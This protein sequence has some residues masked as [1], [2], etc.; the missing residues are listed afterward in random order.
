MNPP[1]SNAIARPA[2]QIGPD[3]FGPS[4]T[5][6]LWWLGGAGFLVNSHGTLLAID[7]AISLEP[8]TSDRSEVGFRLLVDLP[9]R[10]S[11]VPHLD[12][13][14]YTHTDVDH[15]APVTARELIRTAAAWVGPQPVIARLRELGV[16]GARPR[17]VKAG[18]RPRFGAVELETT[19][20][21]HAWQVLDPARYGPAFG[22]DDCCGFLVHTPEG[23]IWCTGDTSLLPEHLQTPGVDV[24]LLDVSRGDFHLGPENGAVLANT[25]GS[26][27]IIPHHFGCYDSPDFGAVNGDPSEVAAMIRDGA[28]RVRILAP[29]ER[30]Q[31][32]R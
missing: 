22:P 19:R 14:L 3:A 32:R 20:A 21:D 5:T 7:P 27:Y 26:P 9:L 12:V 16:A 6:S 17:V 2:L 31:V 18:D 25:L 10:A 29:G 30:F 11:E 4:D 1:S 28:R 8:G 24:L 15:L 23:T 13:V